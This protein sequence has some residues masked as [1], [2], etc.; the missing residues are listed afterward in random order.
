M[1]F[2]TSHPHFILSTSFLFKFFHFFIFKYSHKLWKKAALGDGVKIARFTF[3]FV[4]LTMSRD[5]ACPIRANDSNFSEY[6][7][8]KSDKVFKLLL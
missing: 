3:F 7:K 6:L 4:F 8:Y 1:P 2:L 5:F